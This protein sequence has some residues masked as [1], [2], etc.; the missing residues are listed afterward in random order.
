MTDTTPDTTDETESSRRWSLLGLGGALSLCCLFAP[1]AAGVVGGAAAGGTTA[2]L[3][4][5]LV[6]IL[7]S[8]ITVGIIG[9]AVRAWTETDSQSCER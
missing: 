4:G 3:G 2:A 8:A 9:V 5:G 7:V 1:A 6:R